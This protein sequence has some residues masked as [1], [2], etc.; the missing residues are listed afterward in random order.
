MQ[1]TLEHTTYLQ[2]RHKLTNRHSFKTDCMQRLRY[3]SEKKDCSLFSM[4]K[5]LPVTF[6]R[7]DMNK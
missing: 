3:L 6:K 5:N 1:N 4:L 2:N 7:F